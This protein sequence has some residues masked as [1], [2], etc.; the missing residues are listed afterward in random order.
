VARDFSC[1]LLCNRVQF[2]VFILWWNNKLIG[3]IWDQPFS[4]LSMGSGEHIV[5][6]YFGQRLK[7]WLWRFNVT[8]NNISVISW[9][10]VLLVEET[11]E[12]HRP[13]IVTNKF[14]HIMLH[15]VHLTWA[16]F[17]LTTLVVK[18]IDC[19]GSCKSNYHTIIRRPAPTL[20]RNFL[21]S[22][23]IYTCYNKVKLCH[24]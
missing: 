13:A 15:P 9:R 12:S 6:F 19:I 2:F 24:F 11:G 22:V 18:C 3:Q 23:K 8:F 4:Y 14:H 20:D 7:L 16:G 1:S 10:S 21:S 5:F 17:E